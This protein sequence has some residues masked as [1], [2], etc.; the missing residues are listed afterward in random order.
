[1]SMKDGKEFVL[2]K[3]IFLS[4]VQTREDVARLILFPHQVPVCILEVY[5]SGH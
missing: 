4:E 3:R 5:P 1:M 2:G